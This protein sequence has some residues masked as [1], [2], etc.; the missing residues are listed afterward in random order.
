MKAAK[1]ILLALMTMWSA[2][3]TCAERNSKELEFC[4][5]TA[6]DGDATCGKLTDDPAQRLECFR[7]ARG[8]Q[9]DCLERAL[10]DMSPEIANSEDAV[11]PQPA[12]A[13][14]STGST[15][16]T[17]QSEASRNSQ[18]I[19]E[20]SKAP[21]ETDPRA[22]PGNAATSEA[23]PSPVPA[24]TPA[25][26]PAATPAESKA[27]AAPSNPPEEIVREPAKEAA[28]ETGKEMPK[29]DP[30]PSGAQASQAE[31]NW[32][33]S[34]T[35]SPVDYRPLFAAMIL[36]MSRS[37]DGASSL[38]VRC[39]GGR[40]ELIIRTAGA[41]RAAR[42]GALPVDRQIKGQAVVRQNWTLATDAKTAIYADDAVELLRALPEGAQLTLGVPDGANARR[43]ATFLLAGWDAVRKR[44]ETACKWPKAADQASSGKR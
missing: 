34:E 20:A 43:D 24:P 15:G 33:V 16:P 6:R 23:P 35:T 25:P 22:E 11:E 44:A 42:N 12:D 1:L 39:R 3:A 4:I 8:T 2:G 30:G 13:P 37:Q 32:V 10:A 27:A 18:E 9:L 40:T 17:S 36:P 14:A 21:E 26:V 41:W 29:P 28:K 5:Q 19:S 38:A 31:S 7:K